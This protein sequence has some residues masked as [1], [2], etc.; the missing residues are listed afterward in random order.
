MKA[1][2]VEDDPKTA[3]YLRRG[4][5]ESGFAVDVADRGDDG[6]H[7]TSK[8]HYD[9]VVLDIMLPERDGWSVLEGASSVGESNPRLDPHGA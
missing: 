7:L 1:L 9:I 2:L 4:L 8:G 3:M 6:L 5:S